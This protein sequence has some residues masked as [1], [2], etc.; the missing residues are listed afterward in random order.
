[1]FAVINTHATA[2]MTLAS[3]GSGTIYSAGS[4]I[5]S[6]GARRAA[7]FMSDGSDWYATGM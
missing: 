4:A 3:D 5:T 6:L 7:T 2:A 1:M